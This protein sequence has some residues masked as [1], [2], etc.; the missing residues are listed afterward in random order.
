[1]GARGP[2][3][4]AALAD[5]QKPARGVGPAPNTIS[6]SAKRIYGEMAA[7][8]S[9][10]LEPED[11]SQLAICAQAL[12]E[13][14]LSNLSLES[15]GYTVDGPQGPVVNAW[16]KVRSLAHAQFEKSAKALGLSPADRARM[17]STLTANQEVGDPAF[18]ANE[19]A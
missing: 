8:L 3:S 6:Q 18:D 9:D 2:V 1:M 7:M 19:G 17:K 15:E 14:T 4:K 10:R 5:P 16:V 11:E 13:I 12:H